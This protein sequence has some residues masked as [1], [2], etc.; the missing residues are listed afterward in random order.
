M[1]HLEMD[2]DHVNI[3]VITAEEVAL[4][5]SRAKHMLVASVIASMSIIAVAALFMSLWV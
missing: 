3:R 1:T 2:S 5:V 4:H